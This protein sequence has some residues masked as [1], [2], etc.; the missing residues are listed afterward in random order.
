VEGEVRRV[1]EAAGKGGGLI[2]AGSHNLQPDVSPEKVARIFS[3]AK[4]YGKYPLREVSPS[5]R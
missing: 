1:I 5:L 2:L 3:V 4:E